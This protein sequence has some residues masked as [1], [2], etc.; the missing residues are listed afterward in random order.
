ML[1]VFCG[2][3]SYYKDKGTFFNLARGSLYCIIIRVLRYKHEYKVKMKMN[4]KAKLTS[5]LWNS[6]LSAWSVSIENSCKYHV[7]IICSSINT[8]WDKS[9]LNYF[10]QEVAHSSTVH[11]SV[12]YMVIIS[13]SHELSTTVSFP[14]QL[15]LLLNTVMSLTAFCESDILNIFGIKG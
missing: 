4:I 1:S 2:C 13:E 7:A 8:E 5:L 15:I 10:A 3:L 9:V 12:F 6:M 11:A 14:S